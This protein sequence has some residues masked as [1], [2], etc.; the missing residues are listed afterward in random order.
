MEQAGV[1]S[2]GAFLSTA[3]AEVF[4]LEGRCYQTMALLIWMRHR[5]SDCDRDFG[6]G[7]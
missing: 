2:V 3:I 4:D 6:G 1:A 5:L 7:Y